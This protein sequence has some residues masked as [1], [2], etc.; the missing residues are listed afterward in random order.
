VRVRVEKGG[1]EN[2][3]R[4]MHGQKG[5]KCNDICL[6]CYVSRQACIDDTWHIRD[7]EERLLFTYAAMARKGMHDHLDDPV[8]KGYDVWN[9]HYCIMHA[10]IPFG[11]DMLTYMYRHALANNAGEAADMFLKKYKIKVLLSR[12][13][14]IKGSWHIKATEAFQMFQHFDEL[15]NAVGYVGPA[16]ELVRQLLRHLKTLYKWEFVTD[17]DMQELEAYEHDFP[18]FL[19]M[20]REDIVQDATKYR[21]YWHA[22]MWEIP[23]SIH[24]HGSAWKYSSDITE[25]Y[26][27]IIKNQMLDY[28]TRGGFGVNPCVQLMQRM[29]V[30]TCVY[31]KGL[32]NEELLISPYEKVRLRDIL[33]N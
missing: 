13:P 11:K 27:C 10:T 14:N 12:G 22:M 15:C 31:S 29:A 2:W 25:T 19:D 3:H 26:V 17:A 21:N 24:R 8:L 30:R 7:R 23:E 6:H 28:T 5:G 1:D 33:L 16:N 18:I 9:I 32:G 4:C 20:W